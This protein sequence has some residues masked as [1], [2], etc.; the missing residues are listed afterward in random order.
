ME[1]RRAMERGIPP[2]L[3]MGCTKLCRD[4]FLLAYRSR[5]VGIDKLKAPYIPVEGSCNNISDV[6]VRAQGSFEL[7]RTIVVPQKTKVPGTASFSAGEPRKRARM[8][9]TLHNAS[10]RL[11]IDSQSDSCKFFSVPRF[12]RNKTWGDVLMETLPDSNDSPK[13]LADISGNDEFKTSSSSPIIL[14]NEISKI[15][16]FISADLNSYGFSTSV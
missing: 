11:L 16:S 2:V 10:N 4:L 7:P 14:M 13:I 9:D 6:G 8:S 1:A 12:K 3:D 15:A 5:T